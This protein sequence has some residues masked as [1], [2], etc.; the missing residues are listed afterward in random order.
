MLLTR[1]ESTGVLLTHGR[2][3]VLMLTHGE[4]GR[5]GPTD[6]VGQ[7]A[8][9]PDAGFGLHSSDKTY[10]IADGFTRE[11]WQGP[12]PCDLPPVLGRSQGLAVTLVQAWITTA[13]CDSLYVCA[14]GHPGTRH[15]VVSS[16]VLRRV[17]AA[18]PAQAVIYAATCDWNADKRTKKDGSPLLP[19]EDLRYYARGVFSWPQVRMH[20]PSL[21]QGRPRVGSSAPASCAGCAVSLVGLLPYCQLRSALLCG[22]VHLCLA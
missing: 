8:S 19:H 5:R 13:A 6:T 11:E 21:A 15:L 22:P 12:H 3:G 20:A 18:L 17:P 1:G 2:T 9:P 10:E 14:L 16:C 4:G 7:E